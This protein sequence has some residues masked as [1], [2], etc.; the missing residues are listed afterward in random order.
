MKPEKKKKPPREKCVKKE[1]AIRKSRH[2]DKP[3][4]GEVVG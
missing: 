1:A 3:H 4:D 2:N